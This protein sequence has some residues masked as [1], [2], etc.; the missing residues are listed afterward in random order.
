MHVRAK[1]TAT[2]SFSIYSVF[3]E[4]KWFL[5]W[6]IL[7][8]NSTI[9]F[10]VCLFSRFFWPWYFLSSGFPIWTFACL[11]NQRMEERHCPRYLKLILQV[12]SAGKGYWPSQTFPMLGICAWDFDLLV[13]SNN[14]E[15][16]WRIQRNFF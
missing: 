6:F 5:P 2:L 4:G 10:V 13:I 1:Y 12:G 8:N 15:E 11:L 7:Q 3:F 16:K 14:L 9:L